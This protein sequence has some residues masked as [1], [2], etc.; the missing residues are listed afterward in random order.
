MSANVGEVQLAEYLLDLPAHL[1]LTDAT[2]STRDLAD[3]QTVLP[4]LEKGH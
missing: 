1:L 3:G 2:S 4:T